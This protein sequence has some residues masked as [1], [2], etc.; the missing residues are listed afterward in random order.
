MMRRNVNLLQAYGYND[1]LLE[2]EI[3]NEN[4]LVKRA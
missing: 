4:L 1:N 2:T 3:E